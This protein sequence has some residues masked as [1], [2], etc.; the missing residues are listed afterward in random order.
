MSREQHECRVAPDRPA[1]TY[2]PVASISY[3][4]LPY[5]PVCG[6]RKHHRLADLIFIR[7]D[8]RI[9]TRL[10]RESRACHRRASLVGI[11]RH[12]R[13]KEGVGFHGSWRPWQQTRMTLVDDDRLLVRSLVVATTLSKQRR[14]SSVLSTTIWLKASPHGMYFA[15][16]KG[17][18]HGI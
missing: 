2:K 17:S 13:G 12:A 14:C 16:D 8:L 1:T 4:D 5:P 3:W 18:Q 10:C 11:E 9:F 6:A 7:N 15:G